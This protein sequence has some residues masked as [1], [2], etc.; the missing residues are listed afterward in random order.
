MRI[1]KRWVLIG[2]IFL[3]FVVGCTIYSRTY[4]QWNL[5]KVE[6]MAPRSGTLLLGQYDVRSV[7]KKEEGS[8]GFTHSTQI[9]LPLTVNYF[10]VDD[11]AEVTLT[12][13]RN[14]T[15]GGRVTSITNT[16]E[17]L[18]LTIGFHAENFADGESVDVSIM[19]ETNLL[20]N[21]MPKSALHEDDKGAYL[22]V[23]MKEQGAWGR[24]YVVRRMDVTVWVSTEQEFSVNS[25]I[26]YPVVFASDSNLADGQRVRFYP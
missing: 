26:E 19:K 21:I 18:V 1:R 17:N 3:L 23:V 6:I 14:S 8:S 9:L 22:F 13:I 11:E 15:R 10:Y 2:I 12:G 5:P 25:T 24:E 16:K 20:S 4:Y 7:S